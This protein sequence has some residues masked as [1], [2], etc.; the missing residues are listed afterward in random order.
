MQTHS[1]PH[2][3][4]VRPSLPA[5][6]PRPPRCR[7]P[8]CRSPPPHPPR[9]PRHPSW[10]RTWSPP[11]AEAQGRAPTDG[12]VSRAG[13][14]GPTHRQACRHRKQHSASAQPPCHP[15]AGGVG[16]AREAGGKHC[17]TGLPPPQL[18]GASPGGAAWPACAPQTGACR[19]GRC[20]AAGAWGGCGE[21]AA[22]GRGGSKRGR[23][24]GRR[25][26]AHVLRK[27]VWVLTLPYSRQGVATQGQTGRCRQGVVA[28]QGQTGRGRQEQLG[29]H[30]VSKGALTDAG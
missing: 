8:R 2:S 13:H 17:W 3:P 27:R 26:S 6:H 30:E 21:K 18:V 19:C 22:A 23:G 11:V 7:C 5:S 14:R 24:D 15:A 29:T 10:R 9:P 1:R 25:A 4:P 16:L 28:T 12:R 20:P